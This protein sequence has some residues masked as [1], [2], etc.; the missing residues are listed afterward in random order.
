MGATRE[1]FGILVKAMKAVYAYSGFIADNDAFEVWYSLLKDI[2]YDTL[3][4]AVQ[5]H[6]STQTTIPTVADIRKQ[7]ADFM[8]KTEPELNEEEAWSLVSKALERS[9]YY[10]EEE[11]AKLPKLVQKGIGNP[12]IMREMAAMPI[13]VVQSVEKSHFIRVYR[14]E[15][16]KANEIFRLSPA[17]QNRLGGSNNDTQGRI[18]EHTR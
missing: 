6:M 9:L 13:D 4:K 8:P 15:C 16:Q 14:A 10:S 12:A 18:E 1:Q 2:D 5:K 3:A 11:Y 7:A 17:L